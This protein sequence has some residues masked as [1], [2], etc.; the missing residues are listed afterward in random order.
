VAVD[1][2]NPYTPAIREF[3]RNTLTHLP[4]F[5]YHYL[6]KV[7]SVYK[8]TIKRLEEC[9]YIES[10]RLEDYRLNS[11]VKSLRINIVAG[12]E[13]NVNWHLIDNAHQLLDLL[14]PG[15]GKCGVVSH[16][17]TDDIMQRAQ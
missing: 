12:C 17:T 7:K 6:R 4:A 8:S 2:S 11:L 15:T 9:F 1:P 16:N 3:A 5:F 10:T 14:V 13:T